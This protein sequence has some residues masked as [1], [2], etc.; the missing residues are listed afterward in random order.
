[1]YGQLFI[2]SCDNVS[3][4]GG[5]IFAATRGVQIAFSQNVTLEDLEI[6]N[7]TKEGVWVQ[8]SSNCAFRNL[9]VGSAPTGMWIDTSPNCTVIQSTVYDCLQDGLNFQD[10]DN[11]T[12]LE[13]T[14]YQNGYGIYVSS[15][16]QV[17]ISNNSLFSNTG[18]GLYLHGAHFNSMSYNRIFDNLG[19]GIRLQNPS[20][21]NSLF[22]NMVG[23]NSAGN[24]RD[25]GA[26]N[27]WDD[28]VSM[29]NWWSDYIGSGTYSVYLGVDR[30]PMLMAPDIMEIPDFDY[31]FG[32][33]GQPPLQWRS[34]VLR[35]DAFEVYRNGSMIDSGDWDGSTISVPLAILDIGA[36]EFMLVVNNTDGTASSDTVI[37]SVVDTT[38][39]NIILQGSDQ[40]LIVFGSTGNVVEWNVSDSNP[41]NY[42]IYLDDIPVVENQTLPS[43]SVISYSLDTLEPGVY[44]LTLSAEDG[45]GQTTSSTVN[46]TVIDVNPPSITPLSDFSV[47]G[48]T[49]G[50]SVTW[51]V[52]DYD[53]DS[54][55][56]YIEGILEEEGQWQTSTTTIAIDIDSSTLGSY[57][58]TLVLTDEYGNSATDT[59]FVNIEDTTSPFINHPGDITYEYGRTGFSIVW[60][61]TDVYPASY[62]VFRNGMTVVSLSWTGDDIEVPI[63][64]LDPGIYNYTIVVYDESGNQVSDTVEVEVTGAIPLDP[65]LVLQIVGVALGATTGLAGGIRWLRAR[66]KRTLEPSPPPFEDTPSPS[67]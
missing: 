59:V 48:G 25:E 23:W 58:Y 33:P 5:D 15:S 35:P 57:N 13:N 31:E 56:V 12:V 66:S 24:G 4:K 52:F 2:V 46:V 22:R 63:D 3:L 65:Y 64:G 54:Y 42:T 51:T 6:H 39:P 8:S 20:T 60:E 18:T 16:D 34:T 19:R 43:F 50:N 47:E 36:Y 27:T 61:A 55:S 26:N 10:S 17:T 14:V 45:A 37:V 40:R 11:S 28:G 29:G 41:R 62:E 38:Y 7:S 30:Y 21:N 9:T 49:S 53:P 67:G 1:M 44:D 32:Q